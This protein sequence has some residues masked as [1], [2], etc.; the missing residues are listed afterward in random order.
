MKK[1]LQFPKR[2]W[3]I[4]KISILQLGLVLCLGGVALA[5]NTYAQQE[6]NR[7]ISVTTENKELRKAL[8]QIE[9][10]TNLKF[11]Y[12]PQ[13][14]RAER[15]VTI[16]ANDEPL[17]DILTRLLSPL[18]IRYE[19]I[20]NKVMLSRSLEGV[21][22][23]IDPVTGKIEVVVRGKVTEAGS[24]TGIPGVNVSV[25]GTTVGTTTD[26]KGEYSL[27]LSD[28]NAKSGTLV[29]SFIGYVTQEIALNGQNKI[30]VALASDVKAL[31][32][33]VVVGYGEQ[34]KVTVTG[35]VVSVTGSDLIKSPAVDLTN[36]IAGRMPGITA[37]QTSGEPG[38]DGSSITIRGTNTL[39]NSNALIVID[40]IPDR[41]GGLG[42]ISPQDIESISVLK[43]ASSAIYGARAAN[44][45][46]LVTTK[47]GKTGAPQVTY[48]FNQGWAQPTRIPKMSNATEYATIMN[49]LN[50]Y[51][52]IPAG[53]WAAA[54][55]AIQTNGTYL[56]ND[57]IT[58]VNAAFSPTDMQKYR[59][60]SDPW[61]HPNTDWFKDA[62][63][64]WSPQSRHNLQVSGGSETVKYLASIGY[65]NQDAYYKNSATNYKQY[66]LRFNLDAKVNKYINTSLGI[67]VR[68]ES[69]NFPTQSA[70]SIFRMLM[71]GRPTDPEIWPNGL[72]GPDIE[73][74]QNPIVITTNQTGYQ[75]NPTDYVQTNGKVEITNPWISGLKLTLMGSLDK[76]INRSKTW[77][78]PWY[79]Y[80]WDKITYEADGVTPKLTKAL[81][82]TF[83]DPRLTQTE[84]TILNSNTTALLNY[85]KTFG[86]NHTF[87]VLVG[88]TRE[89][90]TGDNLY[91]YRRNF[92]STAIDQL[93]MGGND[94]TQSVNGGAYNRTRM[95][96]Y[97]R[98]A[99][100]FR[101]KYLAEFIW[102]YDGSYIFPKATRFGFFPGVLLGWNISNEDF[103]KEKFGFIN[104]LKVRGSYGKMGND[105]VFYGGRL[106]EYAYLATYSP[107]EYPINS[108]VVK[109]LYESL[110]PNPTFTWEQANNSNIGLEG[111]VLNDKLDFVFE[112]FY[113]RRTQILIQKLAVTPASSGIQDLLPPVN[114]GRVDNKGFEFKVGYNNQIADFRYSISANAGYARNKVVNMDEPNT[115]PSYQLQTGKPI[116]A[117]LVYQSDGVFKSQQEINENKIDYS[118]VTNTTLRPGDMKFVDVNNDGKINADDQVRLEKS[119]TPTFNFGGTMNFQYKNFDLSILF[120]GATGAVLRFGTESGDIGNYLKYSYDHRWSIDNPSSTDPRLASRGN[121]YYTGGNFGN[122]TYFMFNKNY[123]RLKNVELGYTLPV[124][125]GK[126]VGVH[127]VRFYVNGLNLLTWDKFKIWDPESVSGSG[128]YYPQA[129]VI[130]TGLRL[131]F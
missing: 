83:T 75:K 30:D 68:E 14:I 106:V 25:K 11:N 47:R 97:G 82:S 73:N 125:I 81:R 131:N 102:R 107:S 70:G 77:E 41:D 4:M 72:P 95:G 44:G 115:V 27:A 126:K 87:N 124:E 114:A 2:L 43:D 58:R 37:I 52:T 49:E 84:N 15:K 63:K 34:K 76:T 85:D 8:S 79:L 24:E 59:D 129:R 56:A 119:I 96:Y 62:F 54:N 31:N 36:S 9:K 123:V 118:G 10:I 46:I 3:K 39:G 105:Q 21:N 127:S 26:D 117:F 78:T 32:E 93:F 33:V 40:G 109:T 18:G 113:N 116:G 28:D 1:N 17:G 92:I 99:Y 12:S 120:Q 69:R 71:R 45:V 38:Y 23:L 91:A 88:V 50:I 108:E 7:K 67:M 112:Y 130:N 90:F 16:T 13:V 60:G 5:H 53:E 89:K 98:V 104:F 110:V 29:F 66:N 64:V 128:Q 101:E 55:K 122:N 57:G 42:R 6:L 22:M 61:G 80:T 74:G 86:G 20:G 65:L 35:A 19:L 111:S 94:K 48:D 51:S 121:T 100:N 103:F